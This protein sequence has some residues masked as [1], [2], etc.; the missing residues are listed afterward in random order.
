MSLSTNLVLNTGKEAKKKTYVFT[1][2]Q[3]P[4]PTRNINSGYIKIGVGEA[5]D[6]KKII[7]IEWC[8]QFNNKADAESSFEE[9]KRIF[10]PIST[11]HHF[12]DDEELKEAKYAEF[13]TR[14]IIEKGMRDI[15]F[16]LSRSIDSDTYE[17]KLLPFNE[18]ME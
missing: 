4:L 13:S 12:E 6:I 11:K 5:G 15:T 14:Q 17:I 2:L 16:F 18:F 1:M 3:S 8:L 7:D 10:V 9:L